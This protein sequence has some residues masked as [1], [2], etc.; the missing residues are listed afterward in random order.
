[1]PWP[2][3]P[4]KLVLQL[5]IPFWS[6]RSQSGGSLGG[7]GALWQLSPNFH[8]QFQIAAGGGGELVLAAMRRHGAARE[9]QQYACGALSQLAAN[10]EASRAITD[11]GGQQL[12]VAAVHAHA[13]DAMLCEIARMALSALAGNATGTVRRS[14]L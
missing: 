5:S 14:T 13:D 12:I 1:M 4:N 10:G 6:S 3:I 7:L 11:G 9:L 8:S 2:R